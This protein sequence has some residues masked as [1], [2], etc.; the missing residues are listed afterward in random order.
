MV[1]YM[2]L[3]KINAI[4]L[5]NF[6]ASLLNAVTNILFQRKFIPLK[7]RFKL[8]PNSLS[9][10]RWIL[11]LLPKNSFKSALVIFFI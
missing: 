7:N 11:Q 1:V 3:L 10:A 6:Y 2:Q 8:V 5:F 4:I 9:L